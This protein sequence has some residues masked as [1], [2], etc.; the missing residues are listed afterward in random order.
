MLSD[1]NRRRLLRSCSLLVIFIVVVAFHA[2]VAGESPP[3]ARIWRK[4]LSKSQHVTDQLKNSPRSV[5]TSAM[6][7][8]SPLRNVTYYVSSGMLSPIHTRSLSQMC[9]Y[10]KNVVS[11]FL[12]SATI[13]LK[14]FVKIDTIDS[15]LCNMRCGSSR[16][17]EI[18]ER[19]RMQR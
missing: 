4:R 14:C 13:V 8:K 3:L 7:G 1:E 15:R 10:S 19:T 11:V 9:W 16:G 2:S 12:K 18:E 17:W 6:P 5:D